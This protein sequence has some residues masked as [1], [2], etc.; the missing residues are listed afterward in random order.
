VRDTAAQKWEKGKGGEGHQM[1]ETQVVEERGTSGGGI[2]FLR[3]GRGSLSQRKLEGRL[4]ISSP[5]KKETK[6]RE[7]AGERAEKPCSSLQ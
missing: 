3:H 6:N 5:G 1:P 7:A 2:T 4:R